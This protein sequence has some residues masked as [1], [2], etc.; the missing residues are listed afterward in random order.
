MVRMNCRV[1][2]LLLPL[3]LMTIACKDS[4][5]N[6]LTYANAEQHYQ[7]QYP[8]GWDIQ[9]NPT[10]CQVPEFCQQSVEFKHSDRGE[11]YVFVNFQGGLCEGMSNLRVTDIDVSNQA[12]E[13]Y[14]CP[15]ATIR[16]FGEGSLIARFFRSVGGKNYLVLGQAHRDLDVVTKIVRSFE[17]TMN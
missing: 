6:E 11:V 12:G 16:S 9:I 13:E 2:L 8:E 5:E 17:F 4:G 7:I 14:L 3:F 15:G 10:T 1:L